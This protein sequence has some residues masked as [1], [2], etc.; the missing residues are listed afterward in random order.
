MSVDWRRLARTAG[1]TVRDDSIEVAFDDGRRQVVHV[2]ESKEGVLRLWSI[3]AQ[4]A[5]VRDLID[6][7]L[8][9]WRRNRVTELVGFRLDRRGRII[10]DVL[11]PS[12]GLTSKEWNLYVAAVA[13]ACDRFEYVLTGQD[14][15]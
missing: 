6:P 15:M 2:E 12:L 5:V 8:Q 3:A 1:H 13:R 11:P 4:P 7:H 10:G 14:P 9:V